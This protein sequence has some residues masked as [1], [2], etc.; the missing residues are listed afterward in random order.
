MY[1]RQKRAKR[2]ISSDEEDEGDASAIQI[3]KRQ[4]KVKKDVGIPRVMWVLWIWTNRACAGSVIDRVH[5]TDFSRIQHVRNTIPYPIVTSVL[6][7]LSDFDMKIFV[8]NFLYAATEEQLKDAI[9]TMLRCVHPTSP[10]LETKNLSAICKQI[11]R[12]QWFLMLNTWTE[13]MEAS[14]LLTLDILFSYAGR[15]NGVPVKNPVWKLIASRMP[16]E[17]QWVMDFE[18]WH[19]GYNKGILFDR[20]NLLLYMQNMTLPLPNWYFIPPM[21]RTDLEVIELAIRHPPITPFANHSMLMAW[22]Q[23]NR[24]PSD[25][26]ALMTRFVQS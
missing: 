10:I 13:M 24:A 15:R 1:S 5:L 8:E 14:Q 6:S 7:N 19:M 3:S 11:S 17:R 9:K 22:F 4:K 26:V 23:P 2:V 25:I 18:A 20:G 21:F 16:D 12:T